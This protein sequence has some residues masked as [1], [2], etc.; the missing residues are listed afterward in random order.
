M[1]YNVI[2]TIQST[3]DPENNEPVEMRFYR[4]ED[5]VK[6]LAA[7]VSAGAHRDDDPHYYRVLSVRMDFVPDALAS[8]TDMADEYVGDDKCEPRTFDVIDGDVLDWQPLAT[9]EYAGNPSYQGTVYRVHSDTT[10]QTVLAWETGEHYGTLAAVLE[11]V[12]EGED[13][14]P[15]QVDIDIEVGP[16]DQRK[17]LFIAGP[18]DFEREEVALSDCYFW[19]TR[20]DCAG[21]RVGVNPEGV[22]MCERHVNHPPTHS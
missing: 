14:E 7:L 9:I 19:D 3:L 15:G 12:F 5:Q 2:Q 13:D 4:G 8:L 22:V 20:D 17:S 11:D 10:D 1:Q 18:W 21:P 6:A 16:D